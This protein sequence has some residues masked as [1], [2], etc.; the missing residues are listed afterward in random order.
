MQWL[1]GKYQSQKDSALHLEWILLGLGINGL[2]ECNFG[3]MTVNIWQHQIFIYH[4]L[5]SEPHGLLTD[6]NASEYTSRKTQY[7]EYCFEDATAQRW[8]LM[9][10]NTSGKWDV[11]IDIILLEKPNRLHWDLHIS[12]TFTYQ[13]TWPTS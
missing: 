2:W 13:L 3:K 12:V 4:S 1:L 11:C 9:S 8:L 5:N 10:Q 6:K 7:Y